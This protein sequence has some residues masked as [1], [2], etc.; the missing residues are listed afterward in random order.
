[1]RFAAAVLLVAVL[2]F[3]AH[4][5]KPGAAQPMA[6]APSSADPYVG[7]F[8]G[9]DL[10]ITLQ[11]NG[12]YYVGTA[13][14]QGGQYQLQ[15]QILNGILN[16]IYN[17]N[18]RQ[19]TFQ[20]VVQGDVMQLAAD[21][22]QFMLQRQGAA[23]QMGQAQMGQMQQGQMQQGQMQ[24]GAQAGQMGGGGQLAATAQDQQI[25]QLL[26][27]SRWCS[28]A[29]SQIS[30]RTST[31]QVQFYQD[32]TVSQSG[33]SE[34]Q[35]SNQYGQYYGNSQNGNRGRWRIQNNMLM[36]SADGQQWVPT[37]MQITR[38]SNGYPI[39]TAN[40]KEYSQCN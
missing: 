12:Q 22:T 1:M 10:S 38:N 20:A 27:S 23:G 28:F 7:T 18:G 33:Q 34:T 36:L 32:G 29:Y 30:G 35:S 9:G 14:S 25:A 16:G 37:P 26:L 11:R 15:A 40:G 19:R 4:A 2:P 3:A 8:A 39:V 5:Q 31:E 21:G 24:Q 13:R 17:D 6:A